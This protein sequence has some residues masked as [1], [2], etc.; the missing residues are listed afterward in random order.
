MEE[1]NIKELINYYLKKLPIMFLTTILAIL[2]GYAYVEYYQVPMYHGK[3]TIILIQNNENGNKD[4][5]NETE[6]ELN[7]N[8]KLVT[9]YSEIIK[10]RRVLKQVIT[11]LELELTPKELA[12][13][14]NVSSISETPIIEITVSNSNANMAAQIANEVATVFKLEIV[15][16][17]NLENVSTI[18]EA[19]PEEYPYNISFTKQMLVYAIIGFMLSCIIIFLLYYFDNSIKSKNQIEEKFDIPVLGEIPLSAKLLKKEKIEK[20]TIIEEKSGSLNLESSEKTATTVSKTKKTA[21]PK[22]KSTTK[23]KTSSKTKTTAAKSQTKKEGK[24]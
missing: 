1:L 15:E 19:L 24:K 17:Y 18:D 7:V 12:K 14:I 6:N 3:T 20:V 4:I 10:S 13:Q 23:N 2:I 9:T 11:N 16:L 8:S 22:T 5:I 21:S